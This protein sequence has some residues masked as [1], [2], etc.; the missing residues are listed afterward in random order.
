VQILETNRLILREVTLDDGQF[1]FDLLNTPKFKKYIGDRGVNSLEESREFIDTK[2]RQSYID[3]GYG[4]YAIE[5]KDDGKSV[6]VCGFVRRDSLPGPD[7]GFA[8]LPEFEGKGYG[9]ES[10][11][12][13]MDFGRDTLG[14]T[15]LFAI[16]SQDNEVSGKLLAKL[17]FTF[18]EL[19]SMPNGETLKLFK[20]HLC[21]TD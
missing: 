3:H 10:A 14:F 9:F 8:F 18:G 13:V 6:G 4:L 20:T 5:T 15:N 16:T 21:S 7:I 2:Y 1:I 17:G 11:K 19:I 12:A